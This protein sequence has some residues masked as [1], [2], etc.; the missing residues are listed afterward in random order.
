M[1]CTPSIP[2][3]I[4]ISIPTTLETRT[5]PD[6]KALAGAAASRRRLARAVPRLPTKKETTVA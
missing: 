2:I 1:F 5:H 6:A 3:S 4:P